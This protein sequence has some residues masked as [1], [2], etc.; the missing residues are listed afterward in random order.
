MS[1]VILFRTTLTRTFIFNL[2][3]ELI[4]C[5]QHQFGKTGNSH[6]GAQI[7]MIKVGGL[8]VC[9]CNSRQSLGQL[10]YL[11]LIV[12]A[13]TNVEIKIKEVKENKGHNNNDNNEI[14]FV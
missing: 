13:M 6:T 3:G 4:F 9:V 7:L 1:P 14:T 10:L 11:C 12:E 8:S 5:E 2:P